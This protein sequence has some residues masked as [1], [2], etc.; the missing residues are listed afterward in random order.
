M[1]FVTPK[2]ED[3]RMHFLKVVIGVVLFILLLLPAVTNAQTIITYNAESQPLLFGLG[4]IEIELKKS[5]NEIQTI[6]IT[7]GGKQG[8]IHI[9]VLL[10]QDP[11][12]RKEGFKI[13]YRENRLNIIANDPIG[14]MYGAM[15]VAEQIQMGKTWQSVRD[16]MVNPHFTV[17]ALK[18]NL[19]WSSYRTGLVMDQH[20]EICKDLSFWQSFLDQMATNRFN[21][22]SLWNVHPFSFMV[23]P[24]NFPGAN[25]FSATE[26]KEWRHFWT[27]LFKMA[28]DRGIET[29]IVNWNIA[30]SPEFASTYGVQ[31]RNDTSEIV[32]RYTREV[33]TQVI[34]EYP[35]LSG[36]GI[37]LADWMSNFRSPDSSLPEMNAKDRED[38]IEETVVAGIKNAK[39]PVKFLHRSVLSSDPAEMRRVIN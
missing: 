16:K 27:S 28:K 19:P 10:N 36:I 30:V 6:K 39:R 22:L 17:R 37:T 4:K 1:R 9:Q 8:N 33:V 2:F 31:E 23:K 21:V 12:L 13:Y 11:A 3:T 20:T 35:D 32:K 25:N 18:F 5:G 14:A 34:N 29:F 38:W 7:E 15:D 26:M 24:E